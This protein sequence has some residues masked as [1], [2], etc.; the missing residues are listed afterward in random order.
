MRKLDFPREKTRALREHHES[1]GR[2]S[3]LAVPQGRQW[4]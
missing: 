4:A 2:I 3:P 1:A